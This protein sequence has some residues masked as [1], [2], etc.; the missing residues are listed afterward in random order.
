[1]SK[2]KLPHL[3]TKL[4]GPKAQ[5]VIASDTKYISPSYTR[6]YPLVVKTG[7]GAIVEDVAV[8]LRSLADSD[9]WIEGQRVAQTHRHRH[10]TNTRRHRTHHVSHR[11]L[12]PG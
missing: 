4:P 1:M 2:D 8:H 7:K 12:N 3:I 9:P 10:E 5:K 6:S 11:S